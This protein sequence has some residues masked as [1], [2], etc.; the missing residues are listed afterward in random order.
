[1]RAWFI[2]LNYVH[3]HIIYILFAGGAVVLLLFWL[4][5]EGLRNTVGKD[6]IFRLRQRLYQLER[7][8]SF[9]DLIS[10]PVVMPTRWV[11][12]GT[13]ATT[14]DGGW[15]AAGEILPRP[16]RT[17]AVVSDTRPAGIWVDPYDIVPPF[18]EISTDAA[19][20]PAGTT[21]AAFAGPRCLWLETVAY[22]VNGPQLTAERSG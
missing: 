7:E 5:L 4:T 6:E 3:D 18:D 15:P 16:K 1:M 12:V 14:T 22:S 8:R 10:G 2:V 21:R 17:P 13:A 19:Y 9:A 20:A 11:Q